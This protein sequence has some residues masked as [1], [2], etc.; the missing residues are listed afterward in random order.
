MYVAINVKPAPV[1]TYKSACFVQSMS[2]ASNLVSG[3]KFNDG[4]VFAMLFVALDGETNPVERRFFIE[5]E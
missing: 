5:V 3:N 1:L 4:L 2:A